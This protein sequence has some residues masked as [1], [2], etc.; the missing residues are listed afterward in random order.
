MDTEHI[1]LLTDYD[2]TSVMHYIGPG[3]GDPQLRFTDADRAGALEV[4][5]E[6]DSAFTFVD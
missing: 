2:P 4:Y 3:V 5:G 1:H 6:P